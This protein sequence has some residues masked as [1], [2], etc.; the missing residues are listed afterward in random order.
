MT[1]TFSQIPS[2]D[3]NA[4]ARNFRDIGDKTRFKKFTPLTD[5]VDG[6]TSTVGYYQLLGQMCYYHITLVGTI[7]VDRNNI[8]SNPTIYGLPFGPLAQPGSTSKIGGLTPIA[9]TTQIL[10]AYNSSGF[11]FDAEDDFVTAI[12][13]YGVGAPYNGLPII[14]LDVNTNAGSAI[15]SAG[16]NLH[17]SG[18]FIR[19]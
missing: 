11:N 9:Q 1:A 19:D 13:A 7:V 5:D 8:N 16:G 12:V 3:L 15:Y 17:V 6:V 4:V 10:A 18:W 2:T 14:T